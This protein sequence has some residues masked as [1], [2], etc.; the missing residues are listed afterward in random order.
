MAERLARVLALIDTANAADPNRIA[1]PAG[2]RPAELVYGE[3]MSAM[4]AGFRPVVGEALAIAVRGQHIERWTSP[5]NSYP[6]GRIGYLKWRKDLKDH[7]AARV[8]ELMRQAGYDEDAVARV[9]S[10]IRKERLKHDAEAQALEDVV[11]LVFLTHYAADFIAKHDDA[12]VIDILAKTAA[13]MSAQGLEAASRLAL[14]ERLGRLM[15][16]ALAGG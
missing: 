16:E 5:R 9:A 1:T 6:Q 15:G 4:L 13:K 8:G 10:L 7:H 14:P 3:R 11:C 12:K 2:E